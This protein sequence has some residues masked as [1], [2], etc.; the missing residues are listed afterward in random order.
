MEFM[1]NREYRHGDNIR[2]IDWR[3]TARLNRPIVREYREE[4]FHRVAV[5]L[6]T[7][8][9]PGSRADRE[10]SDADFERAV[11]MCAAI[12]DY[13]AKEEYLVD[14]FAAGSNLYHLTAGRSLAYLDQILDILAAVDASPG[15]PFEVLEPEVMENLAQITTVVCV[16]LDWTESRREFVHRLAAQG[17]AIKVI[18]VRD[19]ACTLDP[20][21]DSDLLGR[22]VVVD[23]AGFEAG[24]EEL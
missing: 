14:I 13:M 3:A 2:D 16:F 21:H 18:I 8:I 20:Q 11:S 12:G 10:R 19:S 7:H 1:G 17:A 9:P 24:M 22:P 15:E 4:F 5:I 6:D 23:A